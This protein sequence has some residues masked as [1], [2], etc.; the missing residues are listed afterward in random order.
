MR[1]KGKHARELSPTGTQIG[2]E[3]PYTLTDE[4]ANK[5]FPGLKN[6]LTDE[7]S[8]WLGVLN[9]VYWEFSIDGLPSILAASPGVGVTDEG[10]IKSSGSDPAPFKGWGVALPAKTNPDDYNPKNK[11]KYIFIDRQGKINIDKNDITLINNINVENITKTVSVH[12]ASFKED[13]YRVRLSD[14]Y[15]LQE[16]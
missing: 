1:I 11:I 9:K 12:W 2:F 6:G 7:I 14:L 10:F 15:K 5:T 16:N 13:L 4:Q 3:D 8:K